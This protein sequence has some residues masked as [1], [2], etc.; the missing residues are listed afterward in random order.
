M[1]VFLFIFFAFSWAQAGPKF[2]HGILISRND[3]SQFN[4]QFKREIFDFGH[5]LFEDLKQCYQKT[6]TSSEKEILE[7]LLS[8]LEIPILYNDRLYVPYRMLTTFGYNT[9]TEVYA[10]I[11]NLLKENYSNS[12]EVCRNYSSLSIGEDFIQNLFENFIHALSHPQW[13]PLLQGLFEIVQHAPD[14]IKEGAIIG[15]I[16]GFPEGLKKSIPFIEEKWFPL[17]LLE[18]SNN[19]GFME[20]L[21]SILYSNPSEVIK[22]LDRVF[23]TLA[24]YEIHYPRLFASNQKYPFVKYVKDNFWSPKLFSCASLISRKLQWA[25]LNFSSE[26]ELF[27]ILVQSTLDAC[28]KL[29]QREAMALLFVEDRMVSWLL[30]RSVTLYY[31]DHI[32]ENLKL[33]SNQSR[34]ILTMDQSPSSPFDFFSGMEELSY[35]HKWNTSR[36]ALNHYATP[37]F[38][39]HE[40]ALDDQLDQKLIRASV[41]LAGTAY[42]LFDTANKI[43]DYNVPYER[44]LQGAL[45]DINLW[46]EATNNSFKP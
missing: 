7:T 33:S 23:S 13:K 11:I 12:Q 46:V 45:Q 34:F 36:T 5:S 42:Q 27:E 4:F 3:P 8:N 26:G 43:K 40:I 25:E 20:A 6:K 10:A 1:R 18:L 32:S 37:F 39:T 9:P 29:S 16:N 28:P 15:G 2:D 17:L 19:E 24:P 30:P 38:L 21:K 41:I 44:A 14:H 31:T 35:W 22:V